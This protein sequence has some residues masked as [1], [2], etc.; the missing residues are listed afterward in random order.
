MARTGYV[1]WLGTLHRRRAGACPPAPAGARRPKARVALGLLCCAAGLCGCSDTKGQP[2]ATAVL[3]LSTQGS[4]AAQSIRGVEVTVT[5]PAGVTISAD[6][7]G[8]PSEGVLVASGAAAG[9]SVAVAG[10]YTAAT[11]SAPGTLTLVLVKTS[12]FE[13]GEFAKVACNLTSGTAPKAAEFG[14]GGFK[15][16]GQ[17]G[18]TMGGLEATSSIAAR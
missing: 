2:S 6:G 18:A 11:S 10:H 4:V 14:L 13:A 12:G 1:P 17:H 16:V 7:S 9:G 3:T 5:L 15:A 8:T